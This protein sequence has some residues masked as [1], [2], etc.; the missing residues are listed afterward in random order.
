M[1]APEANTVQKKDKPSASV[2]L[3]Q[4]LIGQHREE[5][6]LTVCLIAGSRRDDIWYIDSSVSAYI[7]GDRELFT[8]TKR[9]IKM[10]M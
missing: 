7:C 1:P 3:T 9:G 6:A 8:S 5:T 4:V 2:L 10:G